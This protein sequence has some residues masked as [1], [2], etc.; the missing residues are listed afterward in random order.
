LNPQPT[1][2]AGRW[3]VGAGSGGGAWAPYVPATHRAPPTA[4]LRTTGI[5]GSG[6]GGGFQQAPRPGGGLSAPQAGPTAGFRGWAARPVVGRS[7]NF[8]LCA[9]YLVCDS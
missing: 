2:Q 6:W 4:S 8:V 1:T 3:V 5:M 7:V 9:G